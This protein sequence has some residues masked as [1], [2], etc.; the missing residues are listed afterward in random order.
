MKIKPIE[1]KSL[2]KAVTDE[3]IG[4]I[5]QGDLKPGEKLPPQRVL[6]KQ[7]N[8]GMSCVRE[9]IQALNYSQIVDVFPGKGVYVN[10]NLSIVSLLNPLKIVMPLQEINSSKLIELWNSRMLLETGSALYIIENIKKDEVK[11]LEKIYRNMIVLLEKED[12]DSYNSEDLK[13]H[14][15]LIK[16]TGNHILEQLHKF[17]YEILLEIFRIKISS[18]EI[19][20]ISLKGHGKIINGLKKK[21]KEYLEKVL[22][23]H[24]EVSKSD[25]LKEFNNNLRNKLTLK[26]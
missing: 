3:I 19:T 21:D 1:N 22:R 13:F 17:I 7:L 9:G 25:I 8:V 23:E 16:S 4:L 12:L 20:K 2:V 6:A 18:I 11:E 5:R 10:E 14:S 24:I 15:V 26:D